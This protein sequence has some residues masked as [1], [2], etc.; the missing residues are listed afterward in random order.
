MPRSQGPSLSSLAEGQTLDGFRVKAVYLNDADA[1]MGARLEHV[2]TG[3]TLDYLQIQSVPQGFLWVNSFPTSDKGEPHT[4]E[5]LL[6]GKGNK[7]RYSASLE[8]MSLGVS[9]AFT[10]QW[11]TCYHFNTSAGPDV[12]FNLLESRIDALLHP[13][14]TDEEVR[15]E[16]RHFGVVE[17]PDGS[18]RLEEKGTVYNEM[19][20]SFE[21]PWSRLGRALDHAVYGADHPL[22][23][24]SGG[25]PAAI[26]EMTPEDIRRFHRD[27]HHLANMGMIAS[28]PKEVPLGTALERVGAILDRMEPGGKA[29]SG[30]RAM[31]EAD[32]P[33]PKPAP[34][35]RI[36]I[37]DYPHANDTQPGPVMLAWPAALELDPRERILLEL[38]V[39]NIAGDA[40]TN[41]YKRFIDTKTREM[42]IG[43]TAV[44]GNVSND[45]GHPVTISFVDVAAANMTEEKLAAVRRKVV[46]E[47][48]RI[49]SLPD[50]SPELAEFNARIASRVVEAAR[51]MSKF[52]NSPPGF[53]FRGTFSAWMNH[54]E[55]LNKA[56]GFRKSVTM[57]PELAHVEQLLAGKGNFWRTYV[58]KWKLT[59]AVPYV[60]AARANPEVVKREAAEREARAAAEA[61]RLKAAYNAASDQEA[62]RLYRAEYDKTTAELDEVAKK[63]ST[64]RFIDAPPLTLDDQ[65]DYRVEE[66][67]GRVPLVASTFDNMTSATVGL[68]LRLDGVPE[69]DLVYLSLV[70]ELLTQTGVIENGRPVSFE[71]MRERTRKEILGLSANFSSNPLT[72][73][74][75]LVLRGSGNTTA[76]AE[77]AVAW[78]RLALMHPDWRPENLP[79]I[80]DVVDQSL[81][82]LRRTMQSPEEYWVNDPPR[83][84][85]R[86]DNPLMLATSSFLTRAHNAH[87]LRWLLRDA[88]QGPDR[89]AISA[90]LDALAPAGARGKADLKALVTALG[91]TP[92][93]VVPAELAPLEEKFKALPEGA[94]ALAR[95]AARDLE[96]AL[97]EVPDSS[98]AADWAYLCR[99]MRADLLTAPSQA[100]SSLD[101]VR[102]GLLRTGGA[103]AF[104]IGARAAQASLDGEIRGLVGGLERKAAERAA[105][106][107][108]RVVDA[109]LAEREP[110]LKGAGSRPLFV[111]LVNPSTQGGVVVNSA[112]LVTY[113]DTDRESLLRYLASRL[114]GGGGAH[115]IFMKTW[116]AGLAYSNGVGGSPSSG[117]LGYYAERAPE[118]PQTLGFVIRELKAAPR[119]PALV[120]Y[121]VAQ[122]FTEIRAGQPY[123]A[124]GE[125]MAANLADGVTPDAVRAFRSAVLELRKTPAAEL[126]D[127]LY[128]RM[129][130]VYATVLPGYGAKARDVADGVYFIVGPEKQFALYE[131]Y[132]E[133]AEGPD[134]RLHRLYPRDFWLVRAE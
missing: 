127:A 57:K 41:L 124:R 91:D 37:V 20:S 90:F 35:G 107:G 83:A 5:H 131:D 11:R 106:S 112:P 31:S 97:G 105:Y 30:R 60:A 69:R 48:A 26:R 129:D 74:V 109:R 77:R 64:P 3:F 122:T 72:E 76:E 21:R 39:A 87:R 14:Y 111:G 96:L 115:G 63:V 2:A 108:R 56:G 125:A 98:L 24:V 51:S 71:E 78:M 59:T 95:D 66:L 15:R 28:F 89:E 93:G 94:R 55:D 47:V 4:Q 73:R 102:R 84:F 44:S 42:D 82:G 23:F 67:P 132:L 113:K 50:G 25:L 19:V 62:I 46:D 123:E 12:F 13:D 75:E 68:A 45:K 10:M 79:R 17:N 130:A 126:S 32:L 80:R 121:A 38:F 9:S 99:Q 92:S 29:A 85:W 65:L 134:T 88:G 104:V 120:E 103:R 18:L 117:R 116:G 40:T 22:A 110:S 100:L 53:G 36:E 27:T 114:Y 52:V 1:P 118:I 133:S 58:A 81:G 49:A 7:G 54:L 61:A 8:D 128:D 70:P 119:D 86:Q 6:L 16:V 101:A 33:A 34:A 43:A